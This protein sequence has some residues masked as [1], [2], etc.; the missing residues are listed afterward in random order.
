MPLTMYICRYMYAYMPLTTYIYIYMTRP[1]VDCALACL[2]V[3][4]HQDKV[5]LRGLSHADLFVEGVA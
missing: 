4:D 3:A 5:K 1:N 2:F